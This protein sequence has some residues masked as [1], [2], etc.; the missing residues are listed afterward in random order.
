MIF[1]ML[2]YGLPLNSIQLKPACF[3]HNPR[4]LVLCQASSSQSMKIQFIKSILPCFY[5][6]LM[7]Y[8]PVSVIRFTYD[9]TTNTCRPINVI[10]II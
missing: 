5:S 7:T 8:I 2:V 4:D 3:H 9:Y 10:Y 6:Y 1:T